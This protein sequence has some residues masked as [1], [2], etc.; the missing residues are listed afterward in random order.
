MPAAGQKRGGE[1]KKGV[2]IGHNVGGC[3]AEGLILS[4]AKNFSLDVAEI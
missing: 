2:K 4:V 3:M 1:Q